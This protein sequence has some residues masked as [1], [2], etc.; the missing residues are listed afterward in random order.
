MTHDFSVGN[1]DG[2]GGE[3][4]N[5]QPPASH[6]C[7]CQP[8]DTIYNEFKISVGP[9]LNLDPDFAAGV[10]LTFLLNE[11]PAVQMAYLQ[12]VYNNTVNHLS[13]AMATQNLNMTL[14]CIN[15]T[16]ALIN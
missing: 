1:L 5:Q 9:E 4:W 2:F 10:A 14:Q 7:P 3:E 6:Q 11:I 8:S 16:G 13:V 12:A 15:S